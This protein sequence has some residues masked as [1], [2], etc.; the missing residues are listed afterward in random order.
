MRT[1]IL[2]YILKYTIIAAAV[3]GI[4]GVPTEYLIGYLRE[5]K[6]YRKAH[7]DIEL[8]IRVWTSI[9]ASCDPVRDACDK[10]Y[11]IARLVIYHHELEDL[12]E[13]RK[14]EIP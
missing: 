14:G 10:G 8:N 3:V 1:E 11:A 12:E 9:A 7:E 6:A 5:R 2:T 13:T 4:I